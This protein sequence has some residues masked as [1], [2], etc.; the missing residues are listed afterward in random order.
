MGG[1]GSDRKGGLPDRR[2]QDR[3][4]PQVGRHRHHVPRDEPQP[5]LGTGGNAVDDQ[6]VP[7]EAGIVHAGT[8]R[9]LEEARSP[10]F[11]EKD[12]G[13]VALV[14]ISS[15]NSAYEWAGL[16]KGPIPGR[17]GVNPLRATTKYELDHATAEQYKE[18]ARKLGVLSGLPR[19]AERVQ[20]HA[21]TAGG[22]N[23]F[24]SFTFVDGD[25]FEI[26][27]VGHPKDIEGNLRSIDAARQMADL[28]IVAHHN[29]LSEGRRGDLPCRFARE[30]A[31]GGHRR[32]SGHLRRPRLAQGPRDRGLQGQAHAARARQLLLA[33]LL[34]REGAS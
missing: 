18:G 12:K 17:P 10:A 9:D 15:G 19:H 25:K 14:S 8:G 11:L 27:T 1:A 30:F 5:G 2:P 20:R 22:R 21:G 16:G 33:E 26:S 32:R 6:G 4:R 31:Q 29:S 24:S 3:R 23:R 34:H 7:A 28:V 13:R